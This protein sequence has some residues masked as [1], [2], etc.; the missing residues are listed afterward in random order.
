MMQEQ[1][2]NVDPAILYFHVIPMV[3]ILYI[4]DL[5]EKL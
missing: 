2:R 4:S 3:S 1:W 5:I